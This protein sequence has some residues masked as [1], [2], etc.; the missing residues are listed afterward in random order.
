MPAT[1]EIVRHKEKRR[2]ARQIG[3]Q[4]PQSWSELA[5]F[6]LPLW[7]LP[8]RVSVVMHLVGQLELKHAD[9]GKPSK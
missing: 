5:N 8:A 2:L 1:P 6:R 7:K 9:F 4:R 3:F